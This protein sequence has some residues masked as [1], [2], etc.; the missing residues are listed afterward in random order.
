[1][2]WMGMPMPADGMP[3]MASPAQMRLLVDLEGSAKG[4]RFLELMRAHHVGG[5]LMAEATA[6]ASIE[7]VRNL[8]VRMAATQR[9]EIE[10]FD[11]LPAD[12]YARS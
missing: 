12:E 6:C 1:M 10:V 9:Y 5:V 2:A 3:G 11:Q 8:A 7:R 4:R